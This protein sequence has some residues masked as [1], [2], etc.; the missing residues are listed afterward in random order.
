MNDVTGGA[1]AFVPDEKMLDDL[2]ALGFSPQDV[3]EMKAETVTDILTRRETKVQHEARLESEAE[4]AEAMEA[5]AASA[6]ASGS[7][8]PPPSPS[9]PPA[10]ARR[11]PAI[12]ELRM[13][14]NPCRFFNRV[15]AARWYCFPLT[16]L[17]WATAPAGPTKHR[18]AF[19]SVCSTWIAT[20]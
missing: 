5:M 19:R 18:T 1:P 7:S 6:R 11:A 4:T 10:V 16:H 13:K 17:P 12:S 2:Y 14:S 15:Q 8:S 9:S 20:R 3:F